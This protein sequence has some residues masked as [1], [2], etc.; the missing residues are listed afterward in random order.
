MT[1]RSVPIART[2]FFTVILAVG[3]VFLAPKAA[4]AKIRMSPPKFDYVV[5][6]G[7]VVQDV[8][9][10]VNDSSQDIELFPSVLNFTAREN[11]EVS[12][13]PEIYPANEIRTGTE[14]GEWVELG[15]ESVAVTAG[16]RANF[17]FTIRVPENASPGGHFGLIELSIKAPGEKSGIGITASTGALIFIRVEGDVKEDMTVGDF[18]SDRPS[19]SYLPV[20]FTVRLVNGGN[21]HL[22]PV[23]HI[24]VK[25]M[26][27]RQ[28]AALSVNPQFQ[29]ILPDNARRFSA[30]WVKNRVPE[31]SSE[32]KKQLSNFAFGKYTATLV[33]NYGTQG[34]TV[35]KDYSFFVLP[36]LALAVWVGEGIVLLI[37]L[38]F[39]FKA[40]NKAVIR[41]YEKSK[42]A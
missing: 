14:L 8:V 32:L 30:T 2:A 35:I 6:P 23:G 36:W 10:L 25:N 9:K 18:S 15:Q 41:R 16:G 40:Y 37:V 31:N 5:H 13:S 42:K 29:T 24:F 4:D 3:S 33:L 20:G 39:G 11:D 26:F 19:Y 38:I 17:P 7:D 34:Q 27:G 22:R 12:G 1:H 28:V 21:T